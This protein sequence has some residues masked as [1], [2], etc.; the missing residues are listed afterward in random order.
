[1]PSPFSRRAVL[2]SAGAFAATPVLAVSPVPYTPA[3]AAWEAAD[4]AAAGLDAAK[5]NAAVD[6]AMA[7]RSRGVL[8]LRGGRI[9]L[10]RYA[11]GW[12]ED[13]SL[14]VASVG[15]S[16]VAV[17]I[18]MA[19]D[20]GRIRSLD[21]PA[22]DF[23]PSWRGGPKAN[24]TLRHLMSMTS[25]LDDTGLALR[26]VAGDQYALNAAAPEKDLPGTTWR[27][28][29]AVYHLCFHVLASAVGEPF[30][31]YAQKKLLGPLGMTRTTWLTN[32]GQG[33]NGPVTNYYTAV[34]SAR[35]LGRF[36]LFAQRHGQWA[37]RQL[38]SRQAFDT[39]IAPS[40]ALNPAYGL[41][42]WEN[43]KPG[44]DAAGRGAGLRFPGSPS[45]TFAALGAGGQA[46]MV[47]PSRDLVI[48]RQGDPPGA[49]AMLPNLLAG[50]VGA[51]KA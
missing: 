13:R 33:T 15:K 26:N 47:V 38:V 25:G 9:V 29:T 43:A 28:N 51:V 32:Q 34:C 22:A 19:I 20:D 6:A 30:E 5:L 41:L 2:A 36:G 24:I 42:W 11:A 35:D 14:E 27:Y 7:A 17:L 39:L 16:L 44:V 48:I 23:I 49:E 10:E 3:G 31:A 12:G 4:P 50:V 1:M 37:G 45:D 46:V 40:Q 8:V 18:A 21:Q